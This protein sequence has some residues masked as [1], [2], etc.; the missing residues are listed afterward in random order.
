MKF[1]LN[2]YLDV[3]AR[4]KT[5]G[6]LSDDLSARGY[7]VLPSSGRLDLKRASENKSRKIE[8]YFS[9]TQSK[10]NLEKAA[11]VLLPFFYGLDLAAQFL[12]NPPLRSM[13]LE[14][15]KSRSG[16]RSASRSSSPAPALSSAAGAGACAGSSTGSLGPIPALPDLCGQEIYVEIDLD[17]I[18]LEKLKDILLAAWGL[19]VVHGLSASIGYCATPKEHQE[20][21]VLISGVTIPAPFSYILL[22]E[23]DPAELSRGLKITPEDLKDYGL[24]LALDVQRMQVWRVEFLKSHRDGNLER[25]EKMVFP[26]NPEVEVNPLTRADLLTDSAPLSL[27]TLELNF[28]NHGLISVLKYLDQAFTLIINNHGRA[29]YLTQNR[30]G[31]FFASHN[32]QYSDRQ[33]DDIKI[34]KDFYLKLIKLY[35]LSSEREIRPGFLSLIKA[36]IASSDLVNFNRTRYRLAVKNPTGTRKELEES[37]KKAE[38]ALLFSKTKSQ[39]NPLVTAGVSAGA[40]S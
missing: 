14:K 21:D 40:V 22:G 2:S 4:A 26:F 13:P 27:E 8:V 23:G 20:I 15:I 11:E 29:R 6:V 5:G 12:L 38:V 3:V 16:S 35:L 18:N 28:K 36:K 32:I 7:L 34:L 33:L 9:I 1:I 30:H 39:V 10:A 17:K 24:D 37:V 25:Y 31:P 19:L